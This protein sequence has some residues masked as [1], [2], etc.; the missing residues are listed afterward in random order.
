M[1]FLKDG[2]YGLTIINSTFEDNSVTT[3]AGAIYS[4]GYSDGN[5]TI[6]NSKFINN[7]NANRGGV[8][9]ITGAPVDITDSSFIGNKAID[10]DTGYPV[11]GGQFMII[12]HH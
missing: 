9:F 3:Y 6:I 7:N 12:Q 11:S 5:T 10:K 1:L 8:I 2:D 4:M